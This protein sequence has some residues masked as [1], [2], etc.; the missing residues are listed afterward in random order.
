MADPA[1]L[2]FKTWGGGVLGVAYKD[3]ARPPPRGHDQRLATG[4]LWLN[5]GT[6]T[7]EF[8]QNDPVAV[9]LPGTLGCHCAKRCG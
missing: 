2:S 6:E 8:N 7:P 5:S 3:R 4:S 1:P 9:T